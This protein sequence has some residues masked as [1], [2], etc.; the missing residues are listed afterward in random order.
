MTDLLLS[1]ELLLI[2]LD[3]E[4]GKARGMFNPASLHGALLCDLVER[5]AVTVDDRNKVVPAAAAPGHPA[6]AAVHETITADPRPRSVSHW[7]GM[8]PSRHP[9]PAELVALRLVADGVLAREEG[10]VLGLFRTVRMPETDPGPE[11]AL[12][13]RLRS[14]L[15]QGTTP[16][17]HDALLVALLHSTH[18][19]RAAVSGVDTAQRRAAEKR[20]RAV[21]KGLESD[22]VLKAQ[23][24]A[25]VLAAVMTTVTTVVVTTGGSS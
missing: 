22:P 14:V 24:D 2:G 6:L 5:G 8:L 11:R 25:A 19:V 1:E 16:S 4:S 12:R 10:R 21:A 7:T 20:A 18:Q 9:K 3:D 13:E 23:Y 15:V 17:P